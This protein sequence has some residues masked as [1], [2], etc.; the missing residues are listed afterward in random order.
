MTEHC[1]SLE[2]LQ[3]LGQG[4]R[5]AI[6]PPHKVNKTLTTGLVAGHGVKGVKAIVV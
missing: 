3:A 2:P 4:D 1:D 6:Y 5:K